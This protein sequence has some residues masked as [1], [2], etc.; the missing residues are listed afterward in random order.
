MRYSKPLLR[1]PGTCDGCEKAFSF[2][3]GLNCH[4]EVRDV[5]G[6]LA[7]TGYSYVISEPVV[8]E[9]G[10]GGNGDGGLVDVC[11]HGVRGVWNPQREVLS[12]FKVVNTDAASYIHRPVRAVLGSAAAQKKAKHKQACAERRA[13][14]TPFICSTDVYVAIH[15]E[16]QHF[17]WRLSARLASKREMAY[18]RAVSFVNV[19]LSLANLRASVHCLCVGPGG[20]F[21]ASPTTLEQPSPYSTFPRLSPVCSHFLLVILSSLLFSS[22]NAWVADLLIVSSYYSFSEFRT[23]GQLF[24]TYHSGS[25]RYLHVLKIAWQCGPSVLIS[26]SLSLSLFITPLQSFGS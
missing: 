16:G 4:N 18:S 24:Q 26:L 8:R 5:V 12:D 11:D 14:F 25:G 10:V 9:H 2:D 22:L 15:R 21:S 13:D 3:H 7:S 20:S 6:Q 1:L 19:R 23:Y 17:L